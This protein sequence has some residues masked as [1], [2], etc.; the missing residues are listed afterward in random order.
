MKINHYLCMGFF[1]ILYPHNDL[2]INT[3]FIPK[4]IRPYLKYNKEGNVCGHIGKVPVEYKCLY[5][6]LRMLTIWRFIE[7]DVLEWP[8]FNIRFE[9]INF[10]ICL[11][12]DFIIWFLDLGLIIYYW[13]WYKKTKKKYFKEC[14]LI[15]HNTTVSFGIK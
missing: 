9:I 8:I 15:K 4:E 2:N 12:C 3:R 13:Y 1:Q 5:M 7:K 14:Y 11:L 10:M 6:N